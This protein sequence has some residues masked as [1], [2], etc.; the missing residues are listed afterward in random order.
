MLA[1][2][3]LGLGLFASPNTN[4]IM[5]SVETK[6]YGVASSMIG[7][8]RLFGQML[9]MGTTLIFF[10]LF[11]GRV[12]VTPEVNPRFMTSLRYIFV[13]FIIL[14]A[15]GIFASLSRGRVRRE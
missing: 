11:I 6:H 13:V 8:M 9:S 2:L 7:T 10:T 1:L 3:G 4:A 14:C 5:S 15:I 12:Q